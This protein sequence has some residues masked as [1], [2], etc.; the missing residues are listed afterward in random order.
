MPRMYHLDGLGLMRRDYHRISER[1]NAPTYV[2][3]TAERRERSHIERAAIDNGFDGATRPIVNLL[4]RE[5]N[6]FA[7]LIGVAIG[8]TKEPIEKPD[9]AFA[10]RTFERRLT[11]LKTLYGASEHELKRNPNPLVVQEIKC[12]E[13]YLKK[14]ADPTWV[15]KLPDVTHVGG[16][17]P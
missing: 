3:A 17:T 2:D 4:V 15:A 10:L 16:V 9:A 1:V 8:V 6:V 5:E 11:A 13:H 7:Y 12:I 14:F